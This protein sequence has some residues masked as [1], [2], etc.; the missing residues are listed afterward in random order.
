MNDDETNQAG[1]YQQELEECHQQTLNN[2]PDYLL[3]LDQINKQSG[4]GSMT[5][6]KQPQ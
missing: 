2:D 4:N 5:T 6:V 1:W 3:W